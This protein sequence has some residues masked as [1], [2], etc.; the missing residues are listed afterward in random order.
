MLY[1]LFNIFSL[2]HVQVIFMF[3]KY[4]K[5]QSN[6]KE[7]ICLGAPSQSEGF[8]PR[9][10]LD[11]FLGPSQWSNVRKFRYPVRDIIAIIKR[12]GYMDYFQSCWPGF[13]SQVLPKYCIRSRPVAPIMVRY[14]KTFAT[15]PLCHEPIEVSDR[16][17]HLQKFCNVFVSADKS[18]G[19]LKKQS[20][21][22]NTN[23]DDL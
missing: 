15:M 23:L 18:D 16:S 13:K 2:W 11:F 21:F 5:F 3:N 9:T 1:H 14:L 8:K 12:S 22:L 17:E 7:V 20:L 19:N 6:L 4:S 10:R